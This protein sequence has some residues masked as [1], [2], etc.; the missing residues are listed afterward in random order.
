[1]EIYINRRINKRKVKFKIIEK[2]KVGLV[3]SSSERVI[4]VYEL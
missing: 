2:E 1:V 3:V 4:K